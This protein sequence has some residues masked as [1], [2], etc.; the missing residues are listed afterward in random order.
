MGPLSN[1]HEAKPVSQAWA[2]AQDESATA[3]GNTLIAA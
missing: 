3:A 1:L 2:T